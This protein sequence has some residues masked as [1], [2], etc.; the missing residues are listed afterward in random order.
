[1]LIILHYVKR[2][3]ISN[4]DCLVTSIMAPTTQG[5][6]LETTSSSRCKT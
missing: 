5:H 2:E 6:D 4:V 3:N 1:M